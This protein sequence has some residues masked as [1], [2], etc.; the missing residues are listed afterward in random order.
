MVD[1]RDGEVAALVRGLVAAVAAGLFAAGVPG[2][3]DRV[4]VVERLVRRGFVADRV[5][6]VELRLG[7]E[8]GGVGD[9][10]GGE[11]RLGLLRHVARV[12]AV[13]LA[14]ERVVD[15]EVQRERLLRAERVDERGGDIRE[16]EHVRLVDRLETADRRTVEREAVGEEVVVDGLD[17]QIEV[18]HHAGQV[19][20]TNVD[21]LHV[22]V[23]EVSQQFLGIGEHTSSWHVHGVARLLATLG[24]GGCPA[25]SPLFLPCYV[26]RGASA[27]P[28]STPPARQE[29]RT[30]CASVMT[31]D[32]FS[33]NRHTAAAAP[34]KL[35][36]RR[37]YP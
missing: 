12:A 15:E 22:L 5:E 14:G 17:R 36:S 16:Q 4:D 27:T 3:L 10:A 23:L 6:D 21:E 13:G 25:V 34:G 24:P 37:G 31:S 1:R 8:V 19:T 11:V 18:L 35:S 33:L 32:R 28:R 9:A 7:A 26:P 2:A 29:R 30:D 20:E